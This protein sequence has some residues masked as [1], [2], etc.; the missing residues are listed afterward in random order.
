MQ[1][2]VGR[3]PDPGSPLSL[4]IVDRLGEIKQRI[5]FRKRVRYPSFLEYSI[6]VLVSN[7][8]S[9]TCTFLLQCLLTWHTCLPAQA[10]KMIE[11]EELEACSF[12]PQINL[13]SVYLDMDAYQ[14]IQERLQ[15]LLVAI[16]LFFL[17]FL[18]LTVS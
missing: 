11:K 4:P 10:R 17:F 14:P 6:L 13:S 3:R 15:E 18:S 16:L 5:D 9:N 12:W 8:V 2:I 1:P 7:Y